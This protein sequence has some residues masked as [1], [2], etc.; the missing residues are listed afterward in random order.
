MTSRRCSPSPAAPPRCTRR[1]GLPATRRPC[2]RVAI[3][4][5]PAFSFHYEENLELLRGAG[6]ELVP[7]DPLTDALPEADALILAGGFPEIFGAELS[8]NARLRMQIAA[9][10]RPDPGR[11][12]R[13]AVSDA[14]LDG[15]ADVRRDRCHRDHDPPAHARLSRG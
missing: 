9:F 8:A 7:F 2:K 5:G 14:E 3:A 6:A 15:H 10:E 4:R 12:R 11:V 13:P 1:R